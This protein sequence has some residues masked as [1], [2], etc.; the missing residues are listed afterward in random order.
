MRTTR[1]LV[2][3][4][5]GAIVVAC[6]S[7]PNDPGARI[8]PPAGVIRGTVIYQGPHPCS[9]NG[10]I[11]GNAIV[12]V[13]DRRNPPPPNG[14]AN[15]AVNF[16]DVTGDRLFADEPR[17]Q[18]ND[19]TYC[20]VDHGFTEPITA[21][22]QFEIA[23]L[24][25]G[26]YEL[27]AF[28]DYTGDW[29]P[30]FKFRNLPEQGDIAGGAIDTADALKPINAGNPNY[31]PRFVSV[32]VGVARSVSTL[33]SGLPNPIP[34]YDIPST[35]YVTDNVTVTIGL[36]L[37]LTRPYSYAQ[38]E[39]VNLGTGATSIALSV[40]QSS[41]QKGDI[42]KVPGA[43]ES[44][45]DQSNSYYLPVLTIP[46]DLQVF[47]PPT[48]QLPALPSIASV[49]NFE[50]KFPHLKL[51]W[52]VPPPE[53]S[54]AT[55][56]PFH[57][58]IA[59]FASG[60]PQG[61]G[62]SVWENAALDP[63]TQTYVPQQIAE[64][65]G[66]PSLWPLIVLSKLV[67]DWAP[68]ANGNFHTLDPA[69]LTPQG[70]PKNPVVVIQGIT[71]L[72]GADPSKDSLFSTA[73]GYIVG[74]TYFDSQGR[75]K[76]FKQDHVTVMLRPSVICFDTLFDATN[77]DKRGTLVTPYLTG[78]TADVPNQNPNQQYPLVPTDLLDNAD[79][80]RQ[81]VKNLVSKVVQGCLPKGRYAIN[82]VYPDGQA[83]TVPN[84]AGACSGT[85][86][87]TDYSGLTCTLKQRPVLL[88]QG[89]RAVVE[90][91]GPQDP[92]NC[93]S[94][95]GKVPPTPVQCQAQAQ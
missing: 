43:L 54:I 58:Q 76:I 17:Y 60:N 7:V 27:Q 10:H 22:G 87:A 91:V 53:L 81:S 13:F 66:V 48:A 94:A 95:A 64:G 75:P 1:I 45:S 19:A 38:G 41:D 20:P 26:S 65:N 39:A 68:D 72:G 3:L 69:S 84:E 47:A 28:F 4:A 8:V 61:G 77:P 83:W 34:N 11:V 15:T 46:Q 2:P 24:V 49:N 63:A 30:E 62:F 51:Q 74:N 25:G 89:N 35:G 67:D 14:L 42:S 79:P 70:D 52:G 36:P 5:F 93:S 82:V 32:E 57:M 86:G 16:G 33:P 73:L 59:P 29:L 90:V 44:A 9:R 6:G 78:P 92:S 21:S 12:L 37:A 56:L 55:G 18:G 85:E 88:S 31:Q 23:P 71:L 50:S 40:T 80:K